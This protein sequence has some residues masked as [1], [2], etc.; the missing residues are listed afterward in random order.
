MAYLNVIYIFTSL[1][2]LSH[3]FRSHS[4]LKQQ[5]PQTQTPLRKSNFHFAIF[6]FGVKNEFFTSHKLYLSSKKYKLIILF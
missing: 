2:S 5:L 6:F 3:I 4:K 1:K